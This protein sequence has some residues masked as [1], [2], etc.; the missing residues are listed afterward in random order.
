MCRCTGGIRA[1]QDALQPLEAVERK[2]HLR[3]DDGRSRH[4]NM[5]VLAEHSGV[6]RARNFKII[7]GKIWRFTTTINAPQSC[8]PQN[9][10]MGLTKK[11][12]AARAARYRT[13]PEVRA[14]IRRSEMPL[15]ANADL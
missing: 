10:M 3:A 5:C 1:A 13:T 6:S 14:L 15:L 4:A 8:E 11:A 7:R 9:Q 12:R 2:G